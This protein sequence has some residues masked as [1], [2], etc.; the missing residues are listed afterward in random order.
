MNGRGLKTMESFGELVDEGS[1]VNTTSRISFTS[2][3]DQTLSGITFTT[4]IA[5]TVTTT[6]TTTTT[7][8]LL[9]SL[10]T[11]VLLALVCVR[12]FAIIVFFLQL[13]ELPLKVTHIPLRFVQLA[14]ECVTGACTLCIG[15]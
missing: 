3:A 8:T 5:V 14:P 13:I 2:L 7:I 9:L 4:A 12:C 15:I 10:G 6:S 11:V 1:A